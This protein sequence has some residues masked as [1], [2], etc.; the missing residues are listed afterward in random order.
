MPDRLADA[1]VILIVNAGT[2]MPYWAIRRWFVPIRLGYIG[3]L[4]IFLPLGFDALDLSNGS[5]GGGT[6]NITLGVYI[7]LAVIGV[8]ILIADATGKMRNQELKA[9]SP[10]SSRKAE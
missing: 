3:L 8:F 1:I 7:F 9:P 10:P 4:L 2:A 6:S 5:S